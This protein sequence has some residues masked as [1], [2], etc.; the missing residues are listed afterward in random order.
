MVKTL[1]TSV[2]TDNGWG[3]SKRNRGLQINMTA[4]S[5]QNLKW[6]LKQL[7]SVKD[8]YC[9]HVA[10]NLTV[11]SLH[12]VTCSNIFFGNENMGSES[13]VFLSLFILWACGSHLLPLS[14]DTGS[15]FSKKQRTGIKWIVVVHGCSLR[16]NASLFRW[17]MQLVSY[18]CMNEV[19]LH[20]GLAQC[21][22][23]GKS[24]FLHS[25]RELPIV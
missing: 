6:A 25:E 4:K 10:S 18:Q 17:I 22:N 20:S 1:K 3:N 15:A 8:W 5:K 16:W 12:N 14:V 19:D 9:Y 24:T 21:A 2:I 7:N 11:N 23:L 13:L